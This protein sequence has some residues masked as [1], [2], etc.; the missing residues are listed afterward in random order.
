MVLPPGP[1]RSRARR[2]I[3]PASV[4]PGGLLDGR[5][6]R[7]G[8]GLR[9]GDAP[10]RRRPPSAAGRRRRPRTDADPAGLLD[11]RRAGRV[12]AFGDARF[13]G[14]VDGGALAKG[15]TV[16]SMSTTRTGAGYWLFTTRGRALPFGDA[17]FYGDMSKV[18]LNGPVL[19][20]IPTPTG[21]GLLHGRR[22][23]RDLHLRRRPV[24]RVDGRQPPQRPRP[25]PGPRPRPRRATGWWHPTAACSPSTHRSGARW[26]TSGSTSP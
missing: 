10:R 6:R 14:G 12:F 24:R 26:A 4:T 21:L 16:T 7:T 2:P 13:L 9:R 3:S 25:V 17:R 8:L 11:R 19:D 23:R 18:A 20:S 15:E 1:A 5:R 22:R